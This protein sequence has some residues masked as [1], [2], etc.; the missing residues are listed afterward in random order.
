[1]QDLFIGIDAGTSSIKI[2]CFDQNGRMWGLVRKEYRLKT[3]TNGWIELTPEI[4]W[5]KTC[6]GLKE[7][8]SQLG[9]KS[10]RIRI[11]SIS[12]QAQTF[13]AVDKR[14]KPVRDAI[15]WLDSRANTEAQYI[16]NQFSKT[17]FYKITGSSTPSPFLMLPKLLWFKNNSPHLFK[18][19]HKVL[20]VNDYL[21]LR[22]T[23]N[24]LSDVCNFG[25]SG[26]YNHQRHELWKEGLEKLGIPE[27]IFPE[28]KFPG[29]GA[30][31]I[32]E[33]LANNLGLP[34]KIE[35]VLGANDQS[36]SALGMGNIN[37]GQ[38]TEVTGTA[39]VLY[40]SIKKP[41]YT[42][43]YLPWG[44]HIISD[45]K[46]S[47]VYQNAAGAGLSWIKNNLFRCRSYDDLFRGV[48]K[49]PL[50]SGG[51]IFTPYFLGKIFPKRN[52]DIRACI[53]GLDL[54]HGRTHLVHAYMESLVWMLKELIEVIKPEYKL[55]IKRLILSGGCNQNQL[56]CQ[57]KADALGIPMELIKNEETAVVGG[58]ILGARYFYN[59][60]IKEIVKKFV[61]RNRV[62]YPQQDQKERYQ[63]LFRHHKKWNAKVGGI[64]LC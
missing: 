14:G 43:Q 18:R 57:M 44:Q 9:A 40:A 45:L 49:I 53:K 34:S 30:G 31:E 63:N 50:G 55:N 3:R 17:S 58:A 16:R 13:I 60:D 39:M 5:Q 54:S 37:H 33:S 52:S 29:E 4:Y 7:L 47:M 46:F 38:V 23:G 22:F 51:I 48:E 6:Q 11:V 24:Y 61:A 59:K 20:Q 12:S 64:N 25:M 10:Q 36:A 42:G 56:L 19:T 1:M 2:G 27:D 35:F 28:L 21:L 26:C 32:L 15:V 62:F 41:N 8:I